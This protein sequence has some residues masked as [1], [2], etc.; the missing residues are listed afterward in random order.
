MMLLDKRTIDLALK[1]NHHHIMPINFSNIDFSLILTNWFAQ[2]K[3]SNYSAL[4][5]S[6]KHETGL[7]VKYEVHNEI[8]MYATQLEF[9]SIEE[10]ENKSKNKYVHSIKKYLSERIIFCILKKFNIDDIGIFI[11]DL[12]NEI[13]HIG[14]PK[15]ILHQ[16]SVYDLMKIS[17]ALKLTIIG[18][19]FEKLSINKQLIYKY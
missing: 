5:D 2:E 18:F 10:G 15:K 9:V 11:S 19:I 8:V 14:K 13:V 12:R 1:E 16:L 7:K 17:L 6:I 4:I 3:K